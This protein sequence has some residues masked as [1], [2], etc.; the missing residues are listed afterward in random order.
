M[1]ET[2]P[3]FPKPK[4]EERPCRF[5]NAC[6]REKPCMARRGARNK[7]KGRRKQAAVAKNVGQI[8]GTPVGKYAS[9]TGNEEN[10]RGP[11]R[12]EVKAGAQ[13]KPIA[14]KYRSAREQSDAA[15][16]TGD[17]RPFCFAAVPDGWPNGHFLWVI[18]SEDLP[19]VVDALGTP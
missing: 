17:P 18:H 11:L 5:C 1:P 7:A 9:Q 4:R 12:V 2:A 15:H 16:A 19:G 10:W 3:G 8:S 13:V 14:T 6:T